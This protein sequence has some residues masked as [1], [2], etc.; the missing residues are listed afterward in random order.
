MMAMFDSMEDHVMDDIPEPAHP[1]RM[2]LDGLPRVLLTRVL[3]FSCPYYSQ[4]QSKHANNTS[5]ADL[6]ASVSAN[7]F[8]ESRPT[9]NAPR[10]KT[11]RTPISW[12]LGSLSSLS[13]AMG[14][15]HMITSS[16][17]L[18][19]ADIAKYI[20]ESWQIPGVSGF[21]SLLAGAQRNKPPN[22]A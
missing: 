22:R 13:C 16:V 6:L 15:V 2:L 20:S 17:I 14:N 3:P 1:V 19:L 21:H 12:R 4:H 18:R 5:T 10:A 7:E 9:H 8:Q 11:T